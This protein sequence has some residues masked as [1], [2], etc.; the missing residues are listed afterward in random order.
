MKLIK[1]SVL[2]LVFF[3][4]TS[5]SAFATEEDWEVVKH[6]ITE[7]DPIVTEEVSQST[8][9]ET[10]APDTSKDY[11]DNSDFDLAK[12]TNG[13][14]VTEVTGST[15]SGHVDVSANDGSGSGSFGGKDNKEEG[16]EKTTITENKT[17]NTTI[18]TQEEIWLEE[19]L[20][21]N[22]SVIE[23]YMA[24]R[25]G[26]TNI[27]IFG[28]TQ[29]KVDYEGKVTVH[30][31]TRKLVK[32]YHY[33]WDIINLSTGSKDTNRTSGDEMTWTFTEVGSYKVTSIPYCKW[34]YG[35]Y[36]TVEVESVKDGVVTKKSKRYWVHEYYDDSYNDAAKKTFNF[37]IS[38]TDL[39][40]AVDFPLKEVVVDPVKEL[41][42]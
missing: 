36:E 25:E 21:F 4:M 41:I 14:R 5:T 29:D 23:E 37:T 1:Y 39:N 12:F 40:K 6:E 38:V 2:F 27:K 3:L 33:D 9:T 8:T 30:N 31:K 32:I 17:I 13:S 19:R 7:L 16:S 22:D 26:N 34:D 24:R 11:A 35:H 10:V 28:G 18:P 15:A 42:E 20:K